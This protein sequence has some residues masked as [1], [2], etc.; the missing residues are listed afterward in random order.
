MKSAKT[1]PHIVSTSANL[2][3]FCLFVITALRVSDKQESTLVD[4]FTALIALLLAISSLLSFCSIRVHD[5]SRLGKQ[6]ENIA[7]NLFMIALIAIVMLIIFIL[8]RL[9]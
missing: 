2:L 4:E 5:D 6:L 9:W 1:A 8:L 3:G 7:D